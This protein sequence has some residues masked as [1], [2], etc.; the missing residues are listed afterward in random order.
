M[1]N[2]AGL[3]A[4][5][6]LL[7]ASLGDRRAERAIE[8]ARLGLGVGAF[9]MNRSVMGYAQA[10]LAWVSR[11]AAAGQ[12][13]GGSLRRPGLHELRGLAG[14]G[15]VL[16]RPRCARRRMGRPASLADRGRDRI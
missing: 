13:T 11:A 15:E 10:V 4:L 1:P 8:E 6:P 16:R 7:L 12:R 3:R 9:R 5:W 2:L 14:S